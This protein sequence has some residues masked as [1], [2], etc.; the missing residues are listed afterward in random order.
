MARRRL[1]SLRWLR[2]ILLAVAVLSACAA[3]AA[4]PSAAPAATATLAGSVAPTLSPSPAAP[5]T[6]PVPQ[7]TPAQPTAAPP[8]PAPD[9]Q[10]GGDAW[11]TVT[12][13]TGWRSPDSPR[14]VDTPAL[15]NPVRIR[16]W[17][18][19]LTTDLQ[20]GLIGRVD[21]QVLLGDRVTVTELADAWARVV[22]PD[23]ATP[24]DAR[25][26]PAWIPVSQLSPIGPS[27]SPSARVAT[28]VTLTAWLEDAAGGRIAEASFGTRLPVLSAAGGRVEVALPAGGVAWL[29]DSS[30]AVSDPGSPALPATADAL[31]ASARQAVGVRY[32]WGGTSGFGF[33]C[34]GL[35]HLVYRA[36]GIALPRDA[37][38]Q[39]AVGTAVA[40]PDRRPGDL[41]F[42]SRD[43]AV[44]HVAIWVGRGSILEAPDIGVATRVV[45]LAGLSY[46]GEL[47]VTRRLLD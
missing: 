31:I 26:Y 36:H 5:S 41:V 8:T 14:A 27:A 2:P 40:P 38:P 3:P 32:L 9:L 11:V 43:G 23:Q 33:D 19:D 39:S 12:V 29:G 10:V 47:S 37:G 35:V 15:A 28:I 45:A 7:P 16:D 22:V 24:L 42:F 44:H 30:V 13:A 46:A 34:S 20:A 4:S 17:L 18:A 25:G 21:T 1:T 6:T